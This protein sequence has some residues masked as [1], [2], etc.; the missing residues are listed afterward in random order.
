MNRSMGGA[1]EEWINQAHNLLLV[2]T[3]CNGWFEDNPRESYAAGWK[4]RR[5]QLPAEVA[6][7]RT[8]HH[9]RAGRGER[10][11][12]RRERS[13]RQDRETLPG[14]AEIR[15]RADDATAQMVMDI[16][17]DHFTITAPRD[18][19]GDRWCF[20][21]DTGNIAPDEDCGAPSPLI[22]CFS[23]LTATWRPTSSPRRCPVIP[24]G[25]ARGV[26]CSAERR[27]ARLTAV[28]RRAQRISARETVGRT[29]SIRP[30][31]ETKKVFLC[32]CIE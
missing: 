11:M 10:P 8:D 25:A 15:L 1:R 7:Q 28:T 31:G 21:L 6:G 13:E 20:Q 29:C 2:Y 32:V 9:G 17:R 4:V 27:K 24:G 14:T 26:R 23:S 22:S 30:V 12:P 16:L 5:P 19:P 3:V 18:Y